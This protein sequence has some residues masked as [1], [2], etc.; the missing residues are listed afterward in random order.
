MTSS[1]VKLIVPDVRFLGKCVQFDC[2]DRIQKVIRRGCTKL[3]GPIRTLKKSGLLARF[4]G[5]HVMKSLSLDP[6]KP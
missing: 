2:L 5:Y 3:C 1:T 4:N 6:G